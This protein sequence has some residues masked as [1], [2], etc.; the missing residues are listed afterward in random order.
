[1][2]VKEASITAALIFIACSTSSF[3]AASPLVV[4]GDRPVTVNLP[5]DT[6]QPSPLLIMLHSASTS[7]A[8]QERY[9]KLAPVAK[10][11]GMIYIAPNGTVGADGKRVWNAAKA[12]CQKSGAPV[13]DVAYISSLIDEIARKVPVDRSRIYL[14]GHSNGAFM[15]LTYACTTGAI[16]GVVS[17]AGAMDRDFKCASS[18]PFAFLQIHGSA[19][20][21]I[22]IDGGVMNGSAYTS[23]TETLQRVAEVNGCSA[24][25]IKQVALSKKDF[26]PQIAGAETTVETLS[27]C[28]APVTYWKIVR[29]SHSPKL[30]SNYAEQVLAF[31]FNQK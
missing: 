4:G 19:D 13:D 12:C 28:K 21:T 16:A 23:A 27:G 29:G 6:S 25:S 31:F 7:G 8:H 15:S 5:A 26:E 30:P 18:K 14:I 3:A 17:L 10:K 2:K 20:R 22:D 1:M 9:M 24:Q 11:L